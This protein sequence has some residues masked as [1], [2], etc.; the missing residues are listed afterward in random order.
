MS[1]VWGPHEPPRKF[2]WWFVGALVFS[3]FI[4]YEIIK[5]GIIIAK[6]F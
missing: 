1:T 4:W 5:A 6:L 3:A 2:N